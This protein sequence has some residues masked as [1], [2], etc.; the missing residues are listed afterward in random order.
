MIAVS[1]IIKGLLTAY[2]LIAIS[3]AITWVAQPLTGG[4]DEILSRLYGITVWPSMITQIIVALEA[5]Q[6]AQ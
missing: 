1:N 6:A 4:P 3:L 2:G 5:M